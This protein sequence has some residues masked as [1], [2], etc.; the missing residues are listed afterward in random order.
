MDLFDLYFPKPVAKQCTHEFIED[1]MLFCQKC[2]H[3]E[4]IIVEKKYNYV[5][6]PMVVSVPYKA[7][8]HFKEKLNQLL[9][10]ENVVVTKSI[11]EL[12]KD[13]K[14][15]EAIKTVLQQHKQK[16]YY[17][18]V[19]SVMKHLGKP[20]PFLDKLEVDKL[21]YLFN[22]FLEVYNK[23]KKLSNVINYHYLLSKL[24]PLINRRD[25]IPHLYKIRNHRKLR[26]H[27][28]T[29]ALIFTEL[30]WN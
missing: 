22:R 23:H 19:Y 11:L 1:G 28:K 29:I 13:C 26:E 7:T 21:V 16:R 5:D 4:P 6:R 9:A 14:D 18:H 27:D 30:D 25:V 17:E 20:I 8:N 10:L 12:C 2:G 15:H 24:L 3:T